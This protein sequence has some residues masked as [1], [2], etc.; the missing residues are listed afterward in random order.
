MPILFLILLCTKSCMQLI[1]CCS[2]MF[3]KNKFKQ[4]I[5]NFLHYSKKF[6]LFLFGRR[7]PLSQPHLSGTCS[8]CWEWVC[9]QRGIDSRSRPFYWRR[10]LR[11][12]RIYAFRSYIRW[13]HDNDC[14]RSSQSP[15]YSHRRKRQSCSGKLRSWG[16]TCGC[17]PHIRWCLCRFS[18]LLKVSAI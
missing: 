8:R 13:C 18:R 14:R 10:T 5:W 7:T 1:L 15:S 11:L 17:R 12:C 9:I 4:N 3:V 16:H 2:K 6:S